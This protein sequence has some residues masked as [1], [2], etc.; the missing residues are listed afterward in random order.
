MATL[1]K[2]IRLEI[3][4]C[5]IVPGPPGYTSCRIPLNRALAEDA[6]ANDIPGFMAALVE[7]HTKAQAHIGKRAR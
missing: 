7:L 6:A 3:T 1:L 2:A 5:L 4:S